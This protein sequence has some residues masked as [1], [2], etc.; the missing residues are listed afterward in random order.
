MSRFAL[1]E[2][3]AADLGITDLAQPVGVTHPTL[4]VDVVPAERNARIGRCTHLDPGKNIL[5]FGHCLS[6]AL[7]PNR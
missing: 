1:A 3:L 6:P 2:K 5:I 4:T 7:I